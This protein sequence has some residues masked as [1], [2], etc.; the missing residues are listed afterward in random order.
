[1][2]IPPDFQVTDTEEALAL[3]RTHPFGMLVHH[4]GAELDADHIPWELETLPAEEGGTRLI[5]HVAKANPLTQQLHDGDPVLVVF[6][7]EHAYISP[8]WYPSK[9]LTHQAVPTWNYRVVHVH[10]RVR[11]HTEQRFVLRVLG[12]LTRSMEQHTQ[13]VLPDALG[14][15]GPKEMPHE[16]LMEQLT[17]IVG[18]EVSIDRIEAKFKLGQ[19]RSDEDRQA[20]AH[21]VSAA[22]HP[23]LGQ[24][25][26]QAGKTRPTP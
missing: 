12:K 23:A 19:N 14:P 1:M 2:Y 24:A 26:L 6:R 3:I 9:R 17:H 25:M 20:A 7:A 22:G 4:H 11:L 16:A 10:G 21:Q 5:G 13:T 18:L 8:N 15:W